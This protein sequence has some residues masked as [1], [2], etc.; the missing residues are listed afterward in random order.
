VTAP[1][2][3]PLSQTVVETV[4]RSCPTARSASSRDA[5]RSHGVVDL[6]PSPVIKCQ[7]WRPQLSW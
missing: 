6:P 3:R 2:H 4:I 1:A 5:K 7:L